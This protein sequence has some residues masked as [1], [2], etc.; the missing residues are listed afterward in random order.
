MAYLWLACFGSSVTFTMNSKCSIR[1][2]RALS[3]TPSFTQPLCCWFWGFFS[4]FGIAPKEAKSKDQCTT[5]PRTNS[6]QPNSCN[7]VIFHWTLAGFRP[8]I[9]TL[10]NHVLYR[11]RT[12]WRSGP[13][14]RNCN[15]HNS[16]L[17]A[18]G[19]FKSRGSTICVYF[20]RF[21]CC[22]ISKS[23]PPFLNF[24]LNGENVF[25][26]AGNLSECGL[27]LQHGN[28]QLGNSYAKS[29]TKNCRDRRS[30]NSCL[31]PDGI[32]S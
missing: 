12:A 22:T 10:D 17:L 15:T 1:L 21:L 13:R 3:G 20:R 4:S 19:T 24:V 7:S 23:V 32:V 25:A 28:I 26:V 18:S 2:S 5:S 11:F 14:N 31:V 27:L 16:D 6:N 29:A 30:T 8:P 9:C